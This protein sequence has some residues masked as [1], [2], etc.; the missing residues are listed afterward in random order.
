VIFSLEAIKRASPSY[1]F[2]YK[3]VV[4][5][6]K[7]QENSVTFSFDVKG[8]RELPMI[9]GELPILPKHYWEGKDA[10]G[11]P[12]D[13]GKT[14]LEV[15]LGSGPYRV[16]EVDAG[17][18][19]TYTRVADWWAKDLPVARGQWNFDQLRF[20]YFRDEV[21]AFE[22][23]KAQELDYWLEYSAKAWATA[24]D[25][26]AVTSGRIKRL[27]VAVRTVAPMQAFA[28]NIRRPQFQDPLVRRAF[29]LAFDFEWSNR[30]LF[31][32][33]YTRIGSYFDNSE[34][35]AVGL[36]GG[37]ELELQN[38]LRNEVPLEVFTTQWKNP[39]NGTPEDV[40]RHLG[41]AARLLAQAGWTPKD[42]VLTNARGV[43]FRATFLLDRSD[44]ERVVLPYIAA[45]D[46][47]GI[48]A[49]LRFVDSSQYQQR[50]NTFDFD[51]VVAT[52]PQSESP[53]NEQRDFWGSD[54]A[55]KEGSRNIIGIR[56][57]AVDK[58]IDRIIHAKDRHW[59]V[60]ATRALDRVLLWN[61]Y[62]VPQW[63]TPFERLAYWDMYRHP[64]RLPARTASFLRVW[65]WDG[66]AA[67]RLNAAPG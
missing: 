39:V 63:Y 60:A 65:W 41:E 13:L 28:F 53:G 58:L 20:D 55:G 17:R 45:L 9:V 24:Y 7:A 31:Y 34:L 50:L 21:P 44:F 52:F 2:Y 4:K 36:P 5:A 47:L 3:N 57:Q 10:N 12:R 43:E 51:I 40:R 1:G 11:E 25:F 16:K 22:A 61:D 30:N 35:Q 26:D 27:Q 18:S 46:K 19:I 42:G 23:F 56:N 37:T 66:E 67:K 6:E 48:K 15:P 59:L 8:N 29:N 54:A 64:Q 62:V 32:D 38:A 49:S 14:T 33:Q